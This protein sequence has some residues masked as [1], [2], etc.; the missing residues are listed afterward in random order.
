MRTRTVTV[1]AGSPQPLSGLAPA[2]TVTVE[3]GSPQ[4]LSG[5]APASVT[6]ER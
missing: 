1:E 2:R 5:L 3:A 6:M 4:P